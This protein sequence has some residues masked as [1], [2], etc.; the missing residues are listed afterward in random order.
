MPRTGLMWL[1]AFLSFRAMVRVGMNPPL[2]GASETES[3]NLPSEWSLS[4]M[5]DFSITPVFLTSLTL[6][7]VEGGLMYCHFPSRP[8]F[9]LSAAKNEERAG[10][11]KPKAESRKPKAESRK[12]TAGSRQPE[13]DSRKL[14]AGSWKPEAGSR[15]PPSLS[16]SPTSTLAH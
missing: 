9:I 2:H 12:P 8:L 7:T 14:E 5:T 6:L 1:Y 15:Q 10:S 16:H 4:I 3:R 13:A 11:R